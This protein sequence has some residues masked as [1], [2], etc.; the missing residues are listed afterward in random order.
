MSGSEPPIRR[1]AVSLGSN[2]GERLANLSFGLQRIR[3]V[4]DAVVVSS[5]YETEPRYVENQPSF[6]NACCTGCTRLTPRQM[7]AHLQD[8]ERSAGRHRGGPRYGPRILDLDLLL[9]ESAVIRLP[10][11][12]VPHPGL[13]ERP[14][15]L[16]PLAEIA[17]DW[18]VPDPGGGADRTVRSLVDEAGDAGVRR[19]GDA[20]L[21]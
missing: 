9:Y 10:E 13:R 8:S 7:L 6:F 2:L 4:A 11:L 21:G 14:F 12:T 17:G 20:D 16:V 18:V 19:L 5:V 1:F 15:I 3:Q